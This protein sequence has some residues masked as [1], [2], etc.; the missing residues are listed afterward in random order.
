MSSNNAT[1]GDRDRNRHALPPSIP[2]KAHAI[3]TGKAGPSTG[4]FEHIHRQ[5]R[6]AVDTLMFGGGE[7]LSEY[8]DSAGSVSPGGN[9]R[10]TWVQGVDLVDT[11]VS[12]GEGGTVL[13]SRDMLRGG[14]SDGQRSQ[15]QEQERRQGHVQ[16]RSTELGTADD[17]ELLQ[18]VDTA[19]QQQQE[20][21]SGRTKRH[22]SLLSTT[23]YNIGRNIKRRISFWDRKASRDSGYRSAE[24]ESGDRSKSTHGAVGAQLQGVETAPPS[25]RF[26]RD[27]GGSLEPLHTVVSSVQTEQN[28]DDLAQVALSAWPAVP[29]T[30]T[31]VHLRPR[32]AEGREVSRARYGQIMSQWVSK[33]YQ[34]GV[35]DREVLEKEHT[36]ADGNATSPEKQSKASQTLKLEIEQKQRRSER[37]FRQ[38]ERA[39]TKSD[40]AGTKKSLWFF[41][42][43][44]DT[45]G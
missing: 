7:S 5:P 39:R 23:M 16:F 44:R 40:P 22:V 32:M 25:P 35:F 12:D 15:Q 26:E 9:R 4:R 41:K 31:P 42:H 21:A 11:A 13:I 38:T 43:R 17:V 2:E 30:R 36:V 3:M 33:A 20:E 24:E 28:H 45:M 34:D 19:A 8:A 37:E 14:P 29:G 18:R 6:M 27:D 10:N 1:G